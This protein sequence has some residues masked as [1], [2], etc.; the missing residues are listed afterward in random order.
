MYF[1][2]VIIVVYMWRSQDNIWQLILPFHY[3]DA[4]IE[5]IFSDFV[6]SIFAYSV[7]CVTQDLI[8]IGPEKNQQFHTMIL[9]H[10]KYKDNRTYKYPCKMQK[11]DENKSLQIQ[12]CLLIYGKMLYHGLLWS[13]EEQMLKVSSWHSTYRHLL[14]KW[15]VMDF[16]HTILKAESNEEASQS[17][18]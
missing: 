17:S 5:L 9:S 1:V 7:S 14:C 2:G 13:G 11:S 4:K 18:F 15:D 12:F 16:L 6:A 3:V 8:E 10:T